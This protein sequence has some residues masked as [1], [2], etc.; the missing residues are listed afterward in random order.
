MLR[1]CVS[2]MEIAS[3]ASLLHS[4]YFGLTAG[5]CRIPLF[6]TTA[7]LSNAVLATKAVQDDADEYCLHLA[8]F[9]GL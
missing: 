7:L 1:R 3:L 6:L 5:F 4:F 9:G 8:R 2:Y